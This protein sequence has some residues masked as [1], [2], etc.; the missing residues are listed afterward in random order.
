MENN[1][2]SDVQL[3]EAVRKQIEYYF[4]KENLQSD[5]YLTSQMD[6]QMSVPINVVMKFAKLKALTQDEA[7]VREALKES[8][9]VTIS[10][11]RIKSLVKYGTARSTI[12]LR[13]V[14]SDS[15]EEEVKEIFNYPGCKRIV[16]IRSEIGDTW[17]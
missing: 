16:S 4:S 15:P 14:P 5:I 12:I 2:E 8:T 13:D 11:N 3:V 9:L 1:F 6:A 17:Y 10:D 7:L